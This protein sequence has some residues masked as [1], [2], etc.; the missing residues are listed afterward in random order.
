MA[1]KKYIHY[2]VGTEERNTL[3][4]CQLSVMIVHCRRDKNFYNI[5]LSNSLR[6]IITSFSTY[7][8]IE[9]AHCNYLM[10]SRHD[11]GLSTYFYVFNFTFDMYVIH[12]FDTF[13]SGQCCV[14][15]LNDLYVKSTI[16]RKDVN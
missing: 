5:V 11:L 13:V 10:Y 7:H 16:R 15:N 4:Q 9:L 12:T 3:G 1:D 8:A 14:K 6:V 2:T